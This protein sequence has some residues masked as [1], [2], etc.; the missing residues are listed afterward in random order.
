MSHPRWAARLLVEL[1]REVIGVLD[2]WVARD[3]PHDGERREP[4]AVLAYGVPAT[5]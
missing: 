4:V 1:S 5:P 2:R 3:V